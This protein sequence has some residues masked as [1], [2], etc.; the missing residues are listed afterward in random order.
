MQANATVGCGLWQIQPQQLRM[1]RGHDEQGGHG[2]Q[3][4]VLNET[5]QQHAAEYAQ[6]AIRT[7]NMRLL[8]LLFEP[9]MT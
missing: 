5:C 9:A 3:K 1:S 7:V 2:R 6:A 8:L 4:C